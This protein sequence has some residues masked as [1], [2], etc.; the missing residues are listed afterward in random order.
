MDKNITNDII[1]IGVDDPDLDI[2]ESQ[3]YLPD[4]MCYNSYVIF[5]EKIAV[6]DTTDRRTGDKWEANLLAALDGRKPDYLIVQ[7]M[8]PD[9]SSSTARFME[10]FPEAKIVGNAKTFTFYDQFFGEK[11]PI[12]EDKKVIIKDKET[13]S[14]G[15]HE[16]T[17]VTAPMVHW[18]EVFMTYD[19][20]DKVFFSADAFGKFG[21]IDAE[22]DEGWSCE[23]R[24]YYF[25]IVGKYGTSVQALFK[26]IAGFEIETICPLHGPVLTGDLTPYL[27]LYQTWSSYEPETHGIFIACAS[28]HGN[29]LA[30]VEKFADI[31]REKG[32]SRVVVSDLTR[33]DLAECIEDAFRHDRMVVAASSYDAG[34]FPVMYDFLHHLEIKLYQNRTVG[35]IENGSWAPAALKTMRPMLE[36]MKNVTILEPAVSIRSSLK[37]ENM[38]D[39]NALAD[40]LMALE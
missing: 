14:L 16:L 18:P 15:S 33:E 31:L 23:A 27:S 3:Y 10:L 22:D 34:V 19:A 39:L 24:R 17:F 21:T 38:A 36:N 35:M 11:H 4:G 37:E 20:K 1:Y 6:M 2:F 40:A 30:A 8:E 32:A 5:D 28:I 29:T 13:L 25:N 9:H 7:H 12:P 26:K